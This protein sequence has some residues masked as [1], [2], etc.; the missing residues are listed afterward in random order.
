M[1]TGIHLKLFAW[2]GIAAL[3]VQLN[4]VPRDYLLF[5]INQD[6]IAQ[7]LCE[8]TTPHCNGHCFLAKQIKNAG[9]AENDKRAE[10]L[11]APLDGQFL[12]SAENNFTLFASTHRQ[13]SLFINGQLLSGWP[14]SL[15]QPPRFV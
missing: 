3:M 15:L 10:C 9:N 13:F 6:H 11:G 1:K 12:R 8:H 4:A 2:L 7:T 14:K 5:R